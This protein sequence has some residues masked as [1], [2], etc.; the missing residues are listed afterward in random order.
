MA[1]SRRPRG[2]FLL[3]LLVL[4]G[5]TFVT[6]SDRSST[7][8]Y[9]NRA[10]SLANQVANPFQSGV[11]AALQP[12]GDFIYG[13]LKYRSLEAQNQKLRE[14]LGSA[15][16]AYVQANAEE[17]EA[18]QVLSQDHLTFI[19]NIPSIAAQVVE[20]GAANFEQ[21]VEINRGSANGVAV[22]QPVV[23][24]GGLVGSVSSVSSH[25][26]TITLI[27]DP[28]STVGARDERSSVVGAAKGEGQGFDL[29][30]EN[31]NIGDA[32]KPG[33]QMVTSGLPLEHFPSGIPLG[34]VTSVSS[35][36]LQLEVSLKPLAALNNLEFVRVLL[37]S[38]QGG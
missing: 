29:Q 24:A 33:D 8:H 38:P 19:S 7:A 1:G 2:R 20:V 26:A 27:D 14:E 28:T 37:W 17:G 23:A 18:D 6:L 34:T 15:Q 9:F 32:V 5:L 4:L 3:L 10:R 12:I 25:L 22:G 31:L 21:T 30:V 11:H 35:G 36:A 16:S 13:A